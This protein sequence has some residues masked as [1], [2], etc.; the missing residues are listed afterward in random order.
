M[1][2]GDYPANT[3]APHEE[4]HAEHKGQIFNL[5]LGCFA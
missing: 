3:H 4:V 1:I 5:F 2:I